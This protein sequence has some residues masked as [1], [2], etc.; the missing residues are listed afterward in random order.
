MKG[1]SVL[2]AQKH[3]DL[4]VGAVIDVMHCIFLGVMAKTL[5]GLWTDIAHCASPFSIR[6]KVKQATN[7]MYCKVPPPLLE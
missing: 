6:R 2:L 3:F 7:Y 4:S 1:A 5:M